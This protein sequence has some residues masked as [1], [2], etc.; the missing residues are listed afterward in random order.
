M[1][2]H[3]SATVAIKAFRCHLTVAVIAANTL[4]SVRCSDAA[5]DGSKEITR[6]QY[7]IEWPFT[8]ERGRLRCDPGSHVVFLANDKTY[9]VNGSAKG[10]AARNGYENV[11]EIWA[12]QSMG[13][14]ATTAP[15]PLDQRKQLFADLARCETSTQ[16]DEAASRCKASVRKQAKLSDDEESLI[17]TEGVMLGWP[18]AS[19]L[20]VSVG[21]VIKDGL[22]LCK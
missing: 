22:A 11:D 19:P 7:G 6:T 8:V 5:D 2:R 3:C 14:P 18:P 15:L 21:R 13:E 17:S 9:A 1:Y 12:I 4:V 20:R 10:A 16:N